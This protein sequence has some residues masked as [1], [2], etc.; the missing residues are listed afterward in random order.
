MTHLLYT[1]AACLSV[2]GTVAL[3]GRIHNAGR[4]IDVLRAEL[5][6]RN[7]TTTANADPKERS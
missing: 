1:L 2:A 5:D 7:T 6:N 3:A 4:W